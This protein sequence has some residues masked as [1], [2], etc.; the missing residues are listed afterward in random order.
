MKEAFPLSLFEFF[1]FLENAVK[2]YKYTKIYF[3]E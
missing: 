3:Q 2:M 1:Y